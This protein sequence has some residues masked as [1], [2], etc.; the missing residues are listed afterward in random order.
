MENKWEKW[1]KYRTKGT[2]DFVFRRG[3][4]FA[5]IFGVLFW[6]YKYLMKLY[7]P[8]KYEDPNILFEPW[9]LIFFTTICIIGGLVWAISFWFFMETKYQKSLNNK[10]FNIWIPKQYKNLK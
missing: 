7:F 9:F 10:D 4:T 8:T 1:E 5:F 6:I 2:L 3:L